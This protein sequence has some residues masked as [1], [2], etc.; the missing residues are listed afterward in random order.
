[1]V[2]EEKNDVYRE[3]LSYIKKRYLFHLSLNYTKQFVNNTES[4]KI[5][6]TECLTISTSY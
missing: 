4:M 1:M 3:Y 5:T 2:I 6:K